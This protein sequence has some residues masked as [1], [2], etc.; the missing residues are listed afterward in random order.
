M[1]DRGRPRDS[2]RRSPVGTIGETEVRDRRPGSSAHA[3][4]SVGQPDGRTVER[5][6]VADRQRRLGRG[7]LRTERRADVDSLGESDG[8]RRREIERAES[9]VL[10]GPAPGPVA[11]E[12]AAEPDVA[13][14]TEA[15]GPR[16]R[17]SGHEDCGHR[18]DVGLARGPALGGARAP[19]LEVDDHRLRDGHEPRAVEPG[20]A[21]GIRRQGRAVGGKCRAP[22]GG[23]ARVGPAV[24]GHPGAAGVCGVTEQKRN[25]S[26]ERS[27]CAGA[28][29]AGWRRLH[30]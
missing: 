11:T 16:T 10:D 29:V 9:R 17:A 14:G 15:V 3:Q 6:V 5:C 7:V 8:H 12:I 20:E 24:L 21:G 27:V 28:G 26:G 25:R 19:E 30:G 1:C 23:Q 18:S 13:V 22:R 4:L 2:D